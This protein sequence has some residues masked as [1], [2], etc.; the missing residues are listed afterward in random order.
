[1]PR[2]S[3]GAWPLIADANTPKQWRHNR[4]VRFGVR[5]R[6][7][8]NW[9]SFREI[10]EWVAEEHRDPG[11]SYV[12]A[13]NKALLNLMDGFRAG[14]FSEGGKLQVLYLNPAS[15]RPMVRMSQTLYEVLFYGRVLRSSGD[16][17]MTRW[18]VEAFRD[19]HLPY[20]WIPRR[21]LAPFAAKLGL[22][23]SPAW[24]EPG[25]PAPAR[26]PVKSAVLSL[27]KQRGPQ[28]VEFERVKVAMLREL[29]SGR[30]TAD[31][32]FRLKDVALASEFS[33]SSTTGRKARLAAMSEFSKKNSVKL[34]E[35]R[36]NKNQEQ[37]ADR[38]LMT[39]ESVIANRTGF[40]PCEEREVADVDSKY[41][42]W[43]RG[44]TWWWD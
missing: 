3:G 13:Y 1:M 38:A 7:D 34:G 25:R 14:I 37:L 2:T 42:T 20:C 15:D 6:K 5:E 29:E 9:I 12:A 31:S 27:T 28:P 10:A 33:T 17:A 4:F 36:T 11:L 23:R 35:T 30:H 43:G 22:P 24:L 19:E 41:R 32:L 16:L 21:M 8:R 44:T 18:S 26:R 39:E 40:Y